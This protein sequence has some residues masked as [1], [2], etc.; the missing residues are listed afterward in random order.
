MLVRNQKL[1]AY[2]GHSVST[3]KDPPSKRP[4]MGTLRLFSIFVRHY[5]SAFGMFA[6]PS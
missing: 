5:F 1:R 2:M 4:R 6:N 3:L